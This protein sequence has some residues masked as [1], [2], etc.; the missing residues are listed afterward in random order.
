MTRVA[1]IEEINQRNVV[2]DGAWRIANPR[3]R[4]LRIDPLPGGLG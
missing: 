1:A 3:L 2:T 4:R